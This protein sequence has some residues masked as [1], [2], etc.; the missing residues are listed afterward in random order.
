LWMWSVVNGNPQLCKIPAGTIKM[1]LT[2]HL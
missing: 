1:S 2:L